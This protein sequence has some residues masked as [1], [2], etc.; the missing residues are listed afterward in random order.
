MLIIIYGEDT[1]RSLRY[2]QKLKRNFIKKF[3]KQK[4]NLD[5]FDLNNKKLKYN[6]IAS[7]F[8][9]TPFLANKRMIIFKDILNYKPFNNKNDDFLNKIDDLKKTEN[10]IVFYEQSKNLDKRKKTTKTLLK[11]L[12]KNKEL[13]N[14]PILKGFALNKWIKNYIRSKN[15]LISNEAIKSLAALIG[16]NLW[17]QEQEINKLIAYKNN[18]RIHT[19]DVELLTQG[20]YQDYIFKLIDNISE[21][22]YQKAYELLEYQIQRGQDIMSIWYLMLRQFRLLTQ[23]KEML[24]KGFSKAEISKKLHIHPYVVTQL[25]KQNKNFTLNKLKKIYKYLLKWEEQFKTNTNKIDTRFL[26]ELF[27]IA[28]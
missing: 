11:K 13:Y 4:L 18:K 26:I 15:G 2:L 12:Q 22:K 21:R 6:E 19:K 1:Y 14:F 27:I 9:S 28:I 3:D 16:P 10:I 8:F 5:E 24:N 25:I 7:S 20:K 23:S 17:Q